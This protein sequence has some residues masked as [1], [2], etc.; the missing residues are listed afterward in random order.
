[1]EQEHLDTQQVVEVELQPRVLMAL[2][3][4][5]EMVELEHLIIF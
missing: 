1:L 5:Q 3:V 4:E 2:L